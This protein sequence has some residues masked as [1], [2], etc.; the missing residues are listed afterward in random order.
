MLKGIIMVVMMVAAT[1]AFSP[2][3]PARVLG[4]TR[5]NPVPLELE[6]Q[7]NPENKWEVK[8]ILDG[9]EKIVTVSEGDSL[10]ESAEKIF[11]S[12][13]VPSSCRNGVC[14]TC[15]A[16]VTEGRNSAKLAVHGLGVPQLDAGFVCSCQV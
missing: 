7:L 4:M 16:Q 14:T 1:R 9:E 15:A 10:L 5:L 6:G 12:G 13:S 11:D 2:R 3:A 8:F